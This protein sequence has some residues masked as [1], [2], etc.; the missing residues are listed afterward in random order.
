MFFYKIVLLKIKS[1][2]QQSFIDSGFEDLKFEKPKVVVSHKMFHSLSLGEQKALVSNLLSSDIKTIYDIET[3]PISSFQ[4]KTVRKL[5]RD[6]DFDFN[7]NK[8]FE[9]PQSLLNFAS[10]CLKNG[11]TLIC[12]EMCWL[13]ASMQLRFLLHENGF[14]VDSHLVKC[15]VVQ[16]LKRFNE[17]LGMIWQT[18]ENGH[19]NAYTDDCEVEYAED[20]LIA[21]KSFGNI[22][23]RISNKKLLK[24]CDLIKFAKRKSDKMGKL[25]VLCDDN[26]WRTINQMFPDTSGGGN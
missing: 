3:R 8:N 4:D 5:K 1:K 6:E 9:N 17:G 19:K 15:M 13:S 21:A 2:I 25:R 20:F 12:G 14:D 24:G 11:W 16:F 26:E 18:L 22:I 10:L 7:T 23:Y